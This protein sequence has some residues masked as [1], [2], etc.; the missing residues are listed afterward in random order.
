MSSSGTGGS[1]GGACICLSRLIR[2]SLLCPGRRAASTSFHLRNEAL[3]VTDGFGD[4]GIGATF[5]YQAFS[6]SLHGVR[7]R[8]KNGNGRQMF[9]GLQK[10]REFDAVDGPALMH[11]IRERYVHDQ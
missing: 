10:A 4:I 3:R 8:Q 9:I 2:V 11:R 6:V 1:A 5:A 7:G